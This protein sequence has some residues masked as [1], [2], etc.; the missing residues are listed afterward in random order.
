[1]DV[2]LVYASKN[3]QLAK[4]KLP[5]PKYLGR[6]TTGPGKPHRPPSQIMERRQNKSENFLQ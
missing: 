2:K 1:M 6:R 4:G 3:Y 5:K